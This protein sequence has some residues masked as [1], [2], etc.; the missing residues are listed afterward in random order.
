M[1]QELY[2]NAAVPTAPF[3]YLPAYYDYR[4]RFSQCAGQFTTDLLHWHMA[5]EFG[6]EP[7]LNQ[8]FIECDPT[9]RI[10]AVNDETADPLY[11]QVVHN[12]AAIR[13]V[14]KFG[15]PGL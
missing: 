9:D 2:V 12:A 11:I 13:P 5:R 1:I 14:S 4:M 10:F 8:A 6:T 7:A 15:I 3:G